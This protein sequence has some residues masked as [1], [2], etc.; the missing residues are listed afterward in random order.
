MSGRLIKL[1]VAGYP[2]LQLRN[3]EPGDKVTRKAGQVLGR[4]EGAQVYGYDMALEETDY[5]FTIVELSHED[6]ERLQEFHEDHAQRVFNPWT[7]TLPP[8]E[9]GRGLDGTRAISG[10]RFRDGGL[11]WVDAKDGHYTVTLRFYTVTEGPT[12]PP[13]EET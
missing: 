2:P 9:P 4:T 10:C 3:R 1:E 6:L 11:S 7:L 13:T 5:E 12:G 8:G